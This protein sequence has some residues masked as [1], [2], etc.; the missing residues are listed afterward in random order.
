L[1]DIKDF[2]NLVDVLLPKGDAGNRYRVGTVRWLVVQTARVA[3]D[4]LLNKRSVGEASDSRTRAERIDVIRDEAAGHADRSLRNVL[5]P[6]LVGSSLV[7]V[8]SERS[9]APVDLNGG[10]T[11]RVRIHVGRSGYVLNR[12]FASTVTAAYESGDE[13]DDECDRY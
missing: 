1:K 8:T 4:L 5:S 12:V 9:V 2:L 6:D 10:D 11:R 3:A 7:V 13:A